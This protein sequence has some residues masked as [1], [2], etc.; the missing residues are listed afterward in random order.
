MVV[1]D[2][3]SKFGR[4]VPSKNKNARTITNSFENILNSSEKKPNLIEND[5]GT[6]FC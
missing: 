5:E 1:I 3:F 4:I 6:E 2:N